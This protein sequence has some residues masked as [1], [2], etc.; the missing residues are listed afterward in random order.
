[1][2]LFFI[3]YLGF[4]YFSIFIRFCFSFPFC[5]HFL[6]LFRK[7]GG[8]WD[9]DYWI[10]ELGWWE[11]MIFLDQFPSA[12]CFL[13]VLQPLQ[14]ILH[15]ILILRL[16]LY[17]ESRNEKLVCVCELITLL[18]KKLITL[19]ETKLC[20]VFV[21]ESVRVS[22]HI[23]ILAISWTT[24]LINTLIIIY[25]KLYIFLNRKIKPIEH[26]LIRF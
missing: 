20:N 26:S 25:L 14:L 3:H 6:W 18:I 7:K 23:S 8:H 9:W 4:V 13:L 11:M 15:Q 2:Q 21:F 12:L 10:Q 19:F 5:Y 22:S 24:W 16:V 17:F 1:M